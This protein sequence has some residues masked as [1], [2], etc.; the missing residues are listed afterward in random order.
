MPTSWVSFRIAN[1]GNHS[2]RMHQLLELAGRLTGQIFD[3]TTSFLIV[4]CELPPKELAEYLQCALDLSCDRLVVGAVVRTK[5]YAAGK[6][7]RR[8]TLH[9]LCDEKLVNVDGEQFPFGARKIFQ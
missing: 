9:Y 8:V 7:P 2:K 3:D 6:M 4:D 1:T 5:V